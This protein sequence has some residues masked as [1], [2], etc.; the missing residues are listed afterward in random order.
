MSKLPITKLTTD[1]NNIQALPDVVIGQATSV[2]ATF[3][4]GGNEIKT[5]VNTVLTEELNGSDGSNKIGH[6]S[7]G[8]IADNVGDAISE[9]SSTIANLDTQIVKTVG[10]QLIDGIKEFTLQ[11]RVPYPAGDNDASSKKYV[12]DTVGGAILGQVPDGSI[13]DLKLSNVAGQIKQRVSNVDNTSDMDKPVSTA[14]QTAL[15]LKANVASPT[16]TGTPLAPTASVTTNTTQ[17]ATT[18]Y[19][20]SNRLVG[21]TTV[22]NA[23]WVASGNTLLPFKKNQAIT[24]VVAIDTPASFAFTLATLGVAQTANIAY[25]ECYAGGVT[26][27]AT[28]VPTGSVTADYVIIKG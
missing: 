2:K 3:D 4:E 15:N 19:V 25:V 21:S 11:P 12:D 23:S 27:Y 9:L 18:A 24:G 26:L 16:F 13:T 5:Y 8:I 1:L 20:R 22:T 7:L 14:Q 28:S 6:T 17:L 10:D